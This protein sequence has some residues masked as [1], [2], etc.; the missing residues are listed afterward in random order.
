MSDRI[1]RLEIE[2]LAP[3]LAAVLAPRVERL[4]YLGEFFKCVG[5]QPR[6]LI[7]FIEFTESAK[8]GLAPEIVET[9]ALTLATYMGNAYERHQHERLSVRLGLGR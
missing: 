4:G 2:D 9:I 8:G 1:P 5:H 6:P 3:E 7:A